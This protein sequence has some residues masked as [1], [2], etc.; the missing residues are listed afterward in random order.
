MGFELNI[1][2]SLFCIVQMVLS[3]TDPEDLQRLFSQAVVN[4]DSTLSKLAISIYPSNETFNLSTFS[5]SCFK[6]AADFNSCIGN[7]TQCLSLR[8]VSTLYKLDADQALTQDNVS[9]ISSALLYSLVSCRHHHTQELKNISSPSS[10]DLV[11]HV[12]PSTEASWGY[13][14][15][16][17]TIINLCSL[18]GALIVPCMK[19]AKYKLLL[20]FMVALAVGTLAGSGL[21]FLIPEAFHL[22]HDDNI[23]YIWKASTVMGGIYLFYV[24]EKIMRMI[25]TRRE[26]TNFKKKR[27]ELATHDTITT[28]FRRIPID[29]NIPEKDFS[30]IPE[31]IG[32]MCN[33]QPDSNSSSYSICSDAASPDSH[34]N[35]VHILNGDNHKGSS[36]DGCGDAPYTISVA[37]EKHPSNGHSPQHHAHHHRHRGEGEIAPVA[38]MIIFG[39]ALHN[40]I[41]GLSIGSAFTQSI[42]T[43]V[44]VSVAVLC[45]EL[46][47]ELGDFAVL[48]NSGMRFKKA[49]FY[50]FLSAC[51]CYIGVIIGILL[52]ENTQSHEWIFAVAGG[53][54]LYISLVDMMPEMNTAAETPEGKQFGEVRTFLLQNVGV[55][56]GY[57]IMLIMA[58][59]GGNI[60]F[61]N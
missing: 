13:S 28:S 10:P 12:M 29:N 42:M 27:D 2:L 57:G 18:T 36:D 59:Y 20:M 1:L 17:V 35:D 21:L 16:F 48:L 31:N 3:L 4:L 11:K 47:H 61:E 40:F 19:L 51:T 37:C 23:G 34:E 50:N 54:F 41:D 22:V 46:P 58:L 8:D 43:G 32:G 60:N 56:T 38:Y 7:R 49:I 5:S 52:G 53:M 26:N 24:T 6:T 14:M 25:N 39:D 9:V 30:H 33:S 45:E 15:L 44:G 55:L